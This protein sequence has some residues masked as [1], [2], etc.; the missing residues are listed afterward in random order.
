MADISFFRTVIRELLQNA[1]DASATQVTVKFETLPSTTVPTPLG[2]DQ[3][4]SIKHVISH[5][6]VQRLTLR[7]NGTPFNA[8]DWARLKRIAEG[9]PDETKIGAFGVGFY[10]VFADCEEP[11]ISSGSEAMAFYWKEN[12]LFT[13]RLKLNEQDRG[14]DTTFVLDYRNTTSQ[15]PGLMPLCQFLAS[16]LA[17]VGLESIE[18]CLD[19]WT[20]L[21]LSKKAAPSAMVS[22]PKDISTKS[23]DGLMQITSVS[24]QVAQIDASFMN[25]IAWKVPSSS[26]RYEGNQ[27]Q[28]TTMSLR[29][30]FSRLTSSTKSQN[31]AVEK[32][33][34]TLC[35]ND[36]TASS[37]SSIF[38]HITAAQVSTL[39]SSS[40][41]R[42]LERAT[43]KPPPKSTTLA[44][45]TSSYI[46]P[47]SGI[48]GA[49]NNQ[50]EIF[51][52]VLPSKSGRIYIGF[53]THQTTGLN[54]HVSAPSLIPTVERESVDLNARYVRTWNV[55]LLRVAGMVCRVAWSIEMS[56]LK[57]QILS[58]ARQSGRSTPQPADITSLLPEA[59]HVSNQFVFREST[60]TTQVGEAIE[61]AFWTCSKNA[62]LEVLSTHGILPSH[63]VRTLPDDLKFL[64]NTP[65]LP[66]AL[67]SGAEDFV[68]R[69]QEFGLLTEVTIADIK[70][71]LD[72]HAL[73]A[74]HFRAFLLWVGPK[75]EKGVLDTLTVK[76]LL[77][78][79]IVI[80][81][82]A[83]SSNKLLAL[84]EIDRFINPSRI[85]TELPVPPSVLPFRFSRNISPTQFLAFGW[86]E[87]QISHWVKWLIDNS[88]N[89]A[90]LTPEQDMTVSPSFSA[91]ILPVLSKHWDS[92]SPDARKSLVE[93]LGKNTVIPTK[94][95]MK[96]PSDAYF[97][98]VKIF[99]DLPI[100]TGLNS[101]KEKLLI[102]LGV[103]KTVDI[104]IIFERLLSNSQKENTEN[105][106]GQAKWS[107]VELIK[108]LT[109]VRH[110]I[111]DS[112]LAKLKRAKICI[113]ET[114]SG[115][116]T[117]SYE[118]G[119]LYEP[120]DSLRALGLP[121]LHWPGKYAPESPEGKFL[122]F[123]G[124]NT[125]P[126]VPKLVRIMAEAAA[127][128][129]LKL[130]D[131]AMSYFVAHHISNGYAA[132]NYA[133]ITSP[134]LPIE[135]GGLSTPANC[136][137]AEGASLFGFKILRRDLHPHASKF[138]VQPHPSIIE[139]ANVLIS[140]RPASMV[141]AKALFE[142]LAG[143]IPDVT[144]K[145]SNR[146]GPTEIVPVYQKNSTLSSQSS[147]KPTLKIRYVSPQ[148]CYIGRSDDYADI[149][150]FVDFGKEANL[151]LLACGSK[152]E[153][154]RLELASILVKEPAVI[155]AKL[156]TS[157]KYL[158]LLQS[159]AETL[160][161]MK[162]DK[163]LFEEMKRAPFLLASK[164][165][166]S[167][168]AIKQVNGY[169]VATDEDEDEDEDPKTI[170]EWQLV[171]ASDAVI[172]DDYGSFSL[173]KESLLAA[174]QEEILEDMYCV[175]GT[176]FL[177][178]LVEERVQH[179]SLSSNQR[180]AAGL[181]KQIFERSRLFLYD[182]PREVI[183]HD[184]RWLESHLTVQIVQYIK[185]RRSLRGRGLSHLEERGAVVVRK[186]KD[187]ILLVSESRTDLYQISQALVHL[188]TNKPRL[189]SII[190]FEMLLKTDLL[191]LRARGYN[192]D[193]ILRRK[194]AE[195]RMVEHKR[196]QEL[197]EARNLSREKSSGQQQ[198]SQE[199]NMP[200]DFPDSSDD[201]EGSPGKSSRS[202]FSTI[203]RH[204]GFDDIKNP[205]RQ[206]FQNSKEGGRFRRKSSSEGPKPIVENGK[207]QDGGNFVAHSPEAMQKKLKSAIKSCRPFESSALDTRPQINQLEETKTYCDERHAHNIMFLGAAGNG[208]RIYISKSHSDKEGFL[209]VNEDGLEAFAG[210]LRGCAKIFDLDL[211]TV[212]IF[213]EDGGRTIAFNTKGSLFCNYAFFQQLHLEKVSRGERTEAAIYWF[214]TLCH[215]L[216]HNLAAHHGPAHGS[217]T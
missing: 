211:K 43:K 73:S 79:I 154:T 122:S 125:F 203:S 165:I 17:F 50:T 136:F 141:E 27:K 68:R 145:V 101:V 102:T 1:A 84:R 120:N 63:Q 164:E 187:A 112:D 186:N 100:V 113:A 109:S 95:G 170:K 67:M 175:L 128:K 74:Q 172:V 148:D 31:D 196:Q 153:P 159:I 143:R 44:I 29:S 193:R 40:F 126:S 200:G 34:S 20:L 89:R 66:D 9:N 215:E 81:E 137:L 155:S 212:S 134:F 124:L 144:A 83:D 135:G 192:V 204:L 105:Q 216:A 176:P 130:R 158:R 96:K 48:S 98:S 82:C 129:D 62:Y 115:P 77:S 214:V 7:N 91:R 6:T 94:A 157:E 206:A 32:S 178:N 174:P 21:K 97:P 180:R 18:L 160:P 202:V 86:Q 2:L 194:A 5:H 108:Y 217:Y 179:G 118:V 208:V 64:E 110:D 140:K 49:A 59:I 90:V 92:L 166:P 30:F 149:F 78:L 85:P 58:K 60:P 75:A 177:S 183:S 37:C 185:L 132:F 201:P 171:K 213:N 147:E 4:A 51:N 207:P 189:H 138:G 15:V 184:A 190:T 210:I 119:E 198:S 156:K 121:V 103:R 150:D 168:P 88:G 142:Y 205:V 167:K 69:L 57:D 99:Q 123:L 169:Y 8:N 46:P 19:D 106:K 116:S 163:K 93:I 45:L 61:D 70:R 195:A 54:A 25:A 209:E 56:L 127:A 162:K 13:R 151:F 22:I 104:N 181:Q 52:N 182:F 87:L 131:R 38:L 36:L 12:A 42:E 76:S 26:S 197:E 191:E 53:P 41:G 111:P 117:Q 173:F 71:E 23:A 114:N 199:P 33:D 139:C 161:A 146:L 24:R 39:V 47:S 3:S 65:V 35:T 11:F 152:H 133:R 55:E 188:I 72:G 16:S 28:D 80:D 14:N 10:S 107:Y